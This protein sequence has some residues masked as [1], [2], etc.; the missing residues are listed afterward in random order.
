M[1]GVEGLLEKMLN[2]AVEGREVSVSKPGVKVDSQQS[3][4]ALYSHKYV[5][6]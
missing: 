6:L 4:Y 1:K 3:I 2:I 5:L